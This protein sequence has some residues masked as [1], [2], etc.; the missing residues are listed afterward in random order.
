MALFHGRRRCSALQFFKP[1]ARLI[2]RNGKFD[3]A[4]CR[5]YGQKFPFS[6]HSGWRC[7][8]TA[9]PNTVYGA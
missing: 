9:S 2:A 7:T 5:V 4:D 3:L 1:R 6:E 8:K